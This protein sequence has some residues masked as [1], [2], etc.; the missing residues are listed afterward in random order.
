M[1]PE[2]RLPGLKVEQVPLLRL[3]KRLLFALQALQYLQEPC[4]VRDLERFGLPKEGLRR[5]PRWWLLRTCH[6][7]RAC[8]HQHQHQHQHGASVKPFYA[9]LKCHQGVCG[10]G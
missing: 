8:K 5:R 10:P 7:A 9:F 6:R 1:A 2:T 4:L 3:G